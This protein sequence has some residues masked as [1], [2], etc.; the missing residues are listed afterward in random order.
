MPSYEETDGR[1]IRLSG[2]PDFNAN[3]ADFRITAFEGIFSTPPMDAQFSSTA[4][5]GAIASGTWLAKE[6]P[7]SL[8]GFIAQPR[9]ALAQYARDLAQSCPATEESTIEILGNGFDIDLQAFVRRYDKSDF[10]L[11]SRLDFTLQLLMLD[12]YLYSLDALEG[13]VGINS[14]SFWYHEYASSW[15]SEYVKN[16]SSW[17]RTFSNYQPPGPYPTELTL[18]PPSGGVTSHRITFTVVGP[19][20]AGE[21]QLTQDGQREM[22]VQ[23]SIPESQEV[24]IDCYQEKVTM[25]GEDITSY[26]YGDILTLEPEGS[27]YM[28]N[29]S[30]VNNTA[31][32]TVVAY[33]AY[34]I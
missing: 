1:S 4:T 32:A 27:T 15:N 28:L 18:A 6:R 2:L 10:L 31:F 5:A 7:L 13:G 25:N 34:E 24:V 11:G 21:W 9:T 8:T 33:P 26:L 30:T 19:L 12:P 14:G 3:D 20:T 16:G 22:W 29:G 23:V 17:Y